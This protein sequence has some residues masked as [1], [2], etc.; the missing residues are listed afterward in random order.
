MDRDRERGS[1]KGWGLMAPG[2]GVLT[3]LGLGWIHWMKKTRLLERE[4][5]I[6]VHSSPK[7]LR[8]SRVWGHLHPTCAHLPSW[9]KRSPKECWKREAS[10]AWFCPSLAWNKLPTSWGDGRVSTA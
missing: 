7:Q 6:W 1:R 2:M 9:A 10:V 3:C 5:V 8:S 4:K